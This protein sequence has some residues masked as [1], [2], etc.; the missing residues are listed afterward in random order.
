MHTRTTRFGS[1]ARL[2]AA[3]SFLI[4]AGCGK[5]CGRERPYT[6][7]RIDSAATTVA[8]PTMVDG[9]FG[10]PQSLGGE[11]GSFAHVVGQRVEPEA[12]FRLDG[13]AIAAPA[14]ETL[15][16]AFAAD[17]D[18]DGSRDAVVW[19]FGADALAGHLLF[20]KGT[21]PG[22]PPAAAIELA[23][24]TAGVMGAPGC[25]GDAALEQIGPHTAAVSVR[26]NCVPPS[27]SP[28]PASRTARWVAV[29]SPLTNPPL[30]LELLLRD[31]PQ[32]E[33]LGL[34]LD[35]SDSD[36]DGRDDLMARISIEG[37]PPPFETGPR[38]SADLRWL[39]RPTGLSREP[40]EPEA[41]LRR[42]ATALLA[43]ASKKADA[44]L[45]PAGVRQLTRLYAWLCSDSGSPMINASSG[46]IRCGVSRALED[47]G[48]S[49]V[50][51]ELARGD[52][53]RAMSA[54]EQMG[55]RPATS[56]AKLRSDLEKALLK[57]APVRA[58]S[59][60]RV[61]HT[62][63]D[64]DTSG[65]PAWGPL[66]FTP[67]GVLL[68]R[69]AGGLFTVDVQTG[70]EG[71]AQ[72]IPSWPGAVVGPDGTVRWLGLY[73]P[74]DGT[75]LRA[76]FGPSSSPPFVV[77]PP[78]E[79][80]P[81]MRDLPVPVPPPVPSR[82]TPGAPPL[83]LGAVPVD[84]GGAGLEA[85]VAG[86]PVLVSPDLA[87]AQPL[88]GWLQEPAHAGSPRSPD[89]RAMVFGT[90]LGALVRTPQGFQLWRPADLEG[91]YA[92]ADLRAC[93]IADGARA[94]AC[95]RDGRL[96]GMLPP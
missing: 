92:Y 77:P 27:A 46:G 26:A 96:I 28:L 33:H 58:P 64:L 10:A 71:G 63:P 31:P 78:G 91:A 94:V 24:L 47:A 23:V 88:S 65:A 73:D 1:I 3:G 50:R 2:A 12:G 87:Q 82:C 43:S 22:K 59:V 49:E 21:G 7:Y 60:T 74:C 4:A 40:D 89:S 38:Q 84:W 8:S 72:G 5:G 52:V 54:F 66:T 69:T 75:W 18:S 67:T 93:T 90:K 11:A 56:T 76:R 37:A 35:A 95:V 32:G 86:E 85:W 19:S 68:V 20:F 13:T 51:A 61:F 45:V 34:E 55:W 29:A 9:G 57:A 80:P 16:L 17:L 44:A 48:A 70:S 25:A 83:R 42:A 81:G 39:D 36:A 62:V 6:P 41:S 53:Q 15:A 79:P 30:R 14:G